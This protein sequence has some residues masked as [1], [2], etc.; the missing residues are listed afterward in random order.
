MAEKKMPH[1]DHE[2]HLCY[3]QNIGFVQ[4]NPEEYRKLVRNP[5]FLCSDC[6]R[7]AAKEEN[8]CKPEKL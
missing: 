4:A 3:L 2:Q 6:G 1:A 8:L 7:A 5:A